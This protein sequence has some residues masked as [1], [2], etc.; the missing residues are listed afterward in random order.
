M[1][2]IHKFPFK[3]NDTV[4]LEMPRGAMILKV[5]K[6][7]SSIVNGNLCLWAMVDTEKPL[8]RRALFV[9][10]T[11]HPLPEERSRYIDMVQDGL[12]VWHI[13]EPITPA[14]RQVTAVPLGSG[15]GVIE[16]R[17]SDS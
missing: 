10:G 2:T 7:A 17:S 14:T 16:H 15:Q 5:G 12:L 9:R 6:E 8:E 1:R 13:L 11:G 3:V 4:T